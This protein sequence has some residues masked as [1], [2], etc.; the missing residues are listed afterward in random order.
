MRL[1][2][3]WISLG[4]NTGWG[5]LSLLQGIF[6]TQGKNTGIP[7]CGWILYQLRHKGSPRILECVAYSFSSGSSQPRNKTG[8]SCIAGGLFTN[9]AKREALNQSVNQTWGLDSCFTAT[10]LLIYTSRVT[11]L[12]PPPPHTSYVLPE[13]IW[14]F[15]PFPYSALCNRSANPL[16]PKQPYNLLLGGLD[17]GKSESKWWKK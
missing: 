8:V 11:Q 6:P 5:S 9:W 1:Y 2:S 15:F 17:N 3:P 7:H 13:W 14:P 12:I 4:Q 16:F 10:V